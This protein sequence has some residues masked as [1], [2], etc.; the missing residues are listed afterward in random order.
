MEKL[1]EKGFVVGL[2]Q[3]AKI[4]FLV[5]GGLVGVEELEEG[6]GDAREVGFARQEISQRELRFAADIFDGLI[7][8][9]FHGIDEVLDEDRIIFGINADRVPYFKTDGGVFEVEH[10][11]IGMF[12]G[13]WPSEKDTFFKRECSRV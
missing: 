5:V 7:P 2:Q 9:C 12:G 8:C 13:A 3:T 6:G 4:V 11:V 10:D 1:G